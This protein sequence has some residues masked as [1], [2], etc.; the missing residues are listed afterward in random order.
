M[1]P[2]AAMDSE[3]PGVEERSFADMHLYTIN[4]PVTLRSGES[5]QVEFAAAP[6]IATKK[7][8]IYD[9]QQAFIPRYYGPDRLERLTNEEFG[10]QAGTTVDILLEIENT[11]KNGLGIALPAG[12]F[13]FYQMDGSSLE[14]TGER[15]IG[16]T[17]P[18]EKLR[19]TMGTAFDLAGKRVRRDLKV[20]TANNTTTEQIEISLRNRK[21]TAVTIQVIERLA[22][23]TN[24]EIRDPVGDFER[25]DS[26]RIQFTVPVPA[27]QEATVAYTVRYTW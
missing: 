4:R 11:K 6:G 8:Y 16:H 22:R 14:F 3:G 18:G 24:W 9:P 27:A 13:R 21:D 26:N 7:V 17:A 25:L 5:K 19:L 2:M 20:D 15:R 12:T 10:S 1:A 23:G